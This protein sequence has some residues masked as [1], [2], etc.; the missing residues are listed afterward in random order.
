VT[1]SDGR[2]ANPARE[3][4]PARRRGPVLRHLVELGVLLAGVGPVLELDHAQLL[5][6]AAEPAT[7]RV[8]QPQLLAV[9]HDLAE[10]QLLEHVVLGRDGSTMTCMPR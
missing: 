4:Y 5:E 8:E 10:Q 7:G 3:G 2:W 1:S 6:P 9:R